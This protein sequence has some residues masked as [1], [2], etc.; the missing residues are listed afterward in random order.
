MS[1]RRNWWSIFRKSFYFSLGGWF[2]V[3]VSVAAVVVAAKAW[4]DASSDVMRAAL[5]SQIPCSVWVV[6]DLSSAKLHRALFRPFFA[7][8]VGILHLPGVVLVAWAAFFGEQLLNLTGLE[9]TALV[10]LFFYVALGTFVN[11]FTAYDRITD[12]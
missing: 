8:M 2:G 1:R 9:V 12:P 6:A 5:L 3:I 4:P 10:V 7:I 11:L